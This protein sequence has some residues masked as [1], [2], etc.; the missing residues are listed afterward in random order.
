[1]CAWGE[2]GGGRGEEDGSGHV[3]AGDEGFGGSVGGRE[4]EVFGPEELAVC[5]C[6]GVHADEVFV[7][8]EVGDRDGVVS[9]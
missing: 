9:D 4:G 1:M 5:D 3:V 6:C 2:R 8:G 7:A